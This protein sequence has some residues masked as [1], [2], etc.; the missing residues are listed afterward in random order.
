MKPLFT[1]LLLV[2]ATMLISSF[3]TT[4]EEPTVSQGT[5]IIVTTDANGQIADVDDY[6]ARWGIRD[7][8]GYTNIRNRPNGKVCMRLKPYTQYEIF[9]EDLRNGWVRIYSI[10]N[11]TEDYQ[12]KLHGSST[13]SYWISKSVVYLVQ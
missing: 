1:S 2:Q 5:S 12:V 11:I 6:L 13:G 10:F 3:T 8:S 4:T 9:S 7:V